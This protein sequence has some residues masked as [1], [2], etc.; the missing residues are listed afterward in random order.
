MNKGAILGA[1]WGLI[2]PILYWVLIDLKLFGIK[3]ALKIVAL[4]LFIYSKI[5]IMQSAPGGSFYYSP[6]I[7]FPFS[8]VVGALIGYVAEKICNSLR[9]PFFCFHES[10]FSPA[11]CTQRAPA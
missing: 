9:R 2:G 11:F 7:I 6:I 4:P 5:F 3:T 8:I 10:P 1:I